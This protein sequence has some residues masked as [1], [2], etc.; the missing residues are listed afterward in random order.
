L[1][2]F[3]QAGHPHVGAEQR[4]IVIGEQAAAHEAGHHRQAEPARE[5]R[6]LVFEAIAPHLDPGHQHRRF[7]LGQAR[8]DL[9]HA[10]GQRLG[11]DRRRR[12]AHDRRAGQIHHVARN[13]DVDRLRTAPAVRQHARDVGRRARRVVEPDLVAGDFAEHPELRI[14]RLG[15]MVQQQAGARLALARSARE[16]HQRRL[17]GIGGGDRI[18]H[19]E[20]PGAVSHGRDAE[21]HVGARREASAAKPTPGSCDSV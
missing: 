17:L 11:V 9:G 20:R 3:R 16:H 14:Q 15:L 13:L 1:R 12:F 6:H 2:H 18:D 21:P 4:R 10:G 7:R 19:V 5:Q 8:Q